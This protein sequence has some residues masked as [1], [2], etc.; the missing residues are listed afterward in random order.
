LRVPGEPFTSCRVTQT[1]DVGC[2]IY[3]YI[4]I[5]FQG[6]TDPVHTFSAL[7]HAAR[8]EILLCGGS[9]SHHHGVG[10]H[11]TMF[12]E[13]TIGLA[14]VKTLKALKVALDPTNVFCV[15]NLFSE[16]HL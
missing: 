14:G 1:Y 5:P 9:I 15:G 3:F 11:R 7:E 2:C 8:E 13:Q 4:A 16:V 10:K 6:L 12:L